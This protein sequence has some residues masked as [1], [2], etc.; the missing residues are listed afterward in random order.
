MVLSRTDSPVPV[1]RRTDSL[2]AVAGHRLQPGD[3]LDVGDG[4]Y[5]QIEVA[6][7]CLLAVKG[8]TRLMLQ[9]VDPGHSGQ[10]H[11]LLLQGWLK[12]QPYSADATP[13]VVIESPTVRVTMHGGS[14]L[15]NAAPDR[16][17]IFSEA[18]TPRLAPLEPNGRAG[19]EVEMGREQLGSRLG[20]QQIK[21]KPRPDPDFI[22]GIPLDM[23]DPLF[24]IADKL[25]GDPPKLALLPVSYPAIEPW[26]TGTS[27]MRRGL[28]TR[29]QSRAHE[30]KFRAEIEA[31]L[32]QLP[33][34]HDILYPPPPPPPK[35]PDGS[36]PQ[37]PATPANTAA[38][39]NA[40]GSKDPSS[41]SK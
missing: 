27:L 13:Q 37:S 10:V 24:P 38:A 20:N 39:A 35:L 25:R 9:R 30:S 12:I 21:V 16:F 8:E 32:A 3:I 26:L 34:W 19:A 29:F 31:H 22:R 7:N 2:N 18:S 17:E 36:R 6:E 41:P 15:L 28:A 23:R 14:A 4:K 5:A 33:E 1:V 40:A 11:I